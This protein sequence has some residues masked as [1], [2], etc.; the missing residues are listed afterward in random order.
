LANLTGII[1]EARL[2]KI[3]RSADWLKVSYLSEAGALLTFSSD[4]L[5]G[6]K[7]INGVLCAFISKLDGISFGQ[8]K[9]VGGVNRT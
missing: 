8:I 9:K 5:G 2:S 3:A 1:D 7:K 4:V 6:I